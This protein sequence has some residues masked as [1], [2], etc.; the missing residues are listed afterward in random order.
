[1]INYP[2]PPQISVTFLAAALC[3]SPLEMFDVF[4]HFLTDMSDIPL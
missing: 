3:S 2:V 1:M 4:D